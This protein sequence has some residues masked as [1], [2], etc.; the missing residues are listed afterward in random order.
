MVQ[1]KKGE[2]LELLNP[3]KIYVI[4]V[5]M[6]YHTITVSEIE[7]RGLMSKDKAEGFWV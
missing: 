5:Y 4:V 2:L 1:I 3:P 6:V 7:K